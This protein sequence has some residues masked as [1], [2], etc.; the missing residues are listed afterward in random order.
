[1]IIALAFGN[2]PAA[3]FMIIMQ[4]I[5]CILLFRDLRKDS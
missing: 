3:G 2:V 5:L 1:M 4:L